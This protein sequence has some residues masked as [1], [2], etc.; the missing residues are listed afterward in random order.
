MSDYKGHSDMCKGG[1]V[2]QKMEPNLSSG[3]HLGKR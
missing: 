2:E 3:N 1:F